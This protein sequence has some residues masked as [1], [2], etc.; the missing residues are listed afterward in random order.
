MILGH[1]AVAN[2]AKNTFLKNENYLFLI[3]SCYGPDFMD[4]P[5]RV[6]FGLAGRG[7]GHSILTF[8]ILSIAAYIFC[9]EF[10]VPMKY[11][12]VGMA[13]WVGHLASDM[14]DPEVLF[15]PFMGPIPISPQNTLMESVYDFY[16]GRVSIACFT[17]DVLCISSALFLGYLRLLRRQ[18][19]P[20]TAKI[21]RSKSR[22]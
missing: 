18:P 15:W 3:F 10:R 7:F 13:M 20:Q 4:K 9:R 6:L 1:L 21:S 8:S 14:V 22:S 2:V 16:V 19:K 11:L 17:L 5:G 12:Y